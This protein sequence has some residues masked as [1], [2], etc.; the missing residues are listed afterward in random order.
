M[1][2]GGAALPRQAASVQRVLGLDVGERAGTPPGAVGI[3]R[4]SLGGR[5]GLCSIID[6]A[7][8][9]LVEEERVQGRISHEHLAHLQTSVGGLSEEP[10]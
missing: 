9:L 2:W 8:R 6:T 7:A 4:L 5:V 1:D 3:G 10:A